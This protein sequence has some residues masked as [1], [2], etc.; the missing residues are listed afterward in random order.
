[1][2]QPGE[3]GPTFQ[4]QPGRPTSGRTEASGMMGTVKEK[5]Q[6][7]A[8]GAAGVA[9]QVKEKAQEWGSTVAQG[10]QRAWEG[11]RDQAREWASEAAEK[12]ENAWEGLGSLIR[13]HP[14]P[15]LL[16]AL[17]IGFV[18]GGGLGVGARRFTS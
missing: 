17:G 9:G 10:A 5:A 2:N 14:V 11:T 12:A 13:R 1:M 6:E 15:S 18:L 8:S 7:L 16:I 4:E 3:H